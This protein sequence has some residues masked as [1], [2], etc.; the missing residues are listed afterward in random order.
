MDVVQRGTQPGTRLF[1]VDYFTERHVLRKQ[2]QLCS[3][4]A[5]QI[6]PHPG[7]L[8]IESSI[9]L[10]PEV[11]GYPGAS[12]SSDPTVDIHVQSHPDL[13]A[14][15]QFHR[16]IELPQIVLLRLSLCSSCCLGT[17]GG[18]FCRRRCSGVLQ[19]DARRMAYGFRM[20]FAVNGAAILCH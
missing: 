2:K 5:S 17:G 7:H 15:Q 19:T 4:R 9:I 20:P 14:F 8:G 11:P 18:R 12:S 10:Y 6:G 3:V 16:E 13:L 1:L